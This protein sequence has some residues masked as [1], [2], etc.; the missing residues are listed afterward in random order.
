MLVI[1]EG[2]RRRVRS[3]LNWDEMPTEQLIALHED[4]FGRLDTRTKERIVDGARLRGWDRTWEMDG[5]AA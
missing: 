2:G 1:H 3:Q 4:N 5:L